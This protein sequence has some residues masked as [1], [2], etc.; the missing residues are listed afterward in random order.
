MR[1]LPSI[2]F[3]LF[4]APKVVFDCDD[5]QKIISGQIQIPDHKPSILLT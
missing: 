1:S 3:S 2:D 5:S 4:L